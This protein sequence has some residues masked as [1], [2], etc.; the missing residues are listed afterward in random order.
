[1]TVGC[2]DPGCTELGAR[3]PAGN[4]YLTL[5]RNY[6]SSGREST[7]REETHYNLACLEA[8]FDRGLTISEPYEFDGQS[9]GAVDNPNT[10]PYHFPSNSP[11]ALKLRKRRYAEIEE[12]LQEEHAH[13]SKSPTAELKRDVADNSPN[14][15]LTRA[16]N[17]SP[18]EQRYKKQG[19]QYARK[20]SR[21]SDE[22]VRGV[23]Q[24]SRGLRHLSPTERNSSASVENQA[25]ARRRSHVLP[26]H[27]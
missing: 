26:R 16:N 5:A 9:D 12:I 13:K 14:L 2:S 7:K 8:I 19:L 6:L 21:V 11:E 17:V 25:M 24:P 22:V 27:A 1:M 15:K 23:S 20:Q 10:F 4:F 18:Y 3:L